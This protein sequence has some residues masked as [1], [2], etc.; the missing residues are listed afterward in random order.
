MAPGCAEA[1]EFEAGVRMSR[2]V[3]AFG[4]PEGVEHRAGIK[5]DRRPGKWTRLGDRPSRYDHVSTSKWVI[6][7]AWFRSRS[8][9]T[10]EVPQPQRAGGAFP[11]S[12]CRDHRQD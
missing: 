5:R 3:S 4:A 10:A 7:Y 8:A 1:S 12:D 2:S 9:P 6:Y 11:I